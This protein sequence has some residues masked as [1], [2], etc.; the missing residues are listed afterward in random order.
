MIDVANFFYPHSRGPIYGWFSPAGLQ[1]IVLPNTSVE[2]LKPHLLHSW[3]NDGRARQLNEALERYFA[4]QRED[5]AEIHLD[6]EDATPFQKTVWN[7]ARNVPWGVE[8]TYGDLAG[9]IGK[10]KSAARAVGAALGAN[11]IAILVPCHRFRAANGDLRGFA[12]GLE[13]KRELL[14]L[15]GSRL[16]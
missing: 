3:V 1:R 5:F 12:A 7:A 4:G 16:V 11:P 8:S 10:P 13:W 6:L 15:E 9:A 2:Y 14:C